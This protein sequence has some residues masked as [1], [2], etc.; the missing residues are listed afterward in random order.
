[1]HAG[2]RAPTRVPGAREASSS[3]SERADRDGLFERLARARRLAAI[4]GN[5]SPAV[6]VRDAALASHVV[7]RFVDRATFAKAEREAVRIGVATV[8]VLLANGWV[9]EGALVGALAWARGLPAVERDPG[10]R[11]VR[12]VMIR[13]APPTGDGGPRL[14]EPV[15]LVCERGRWI[16]LS[17][18]LDGPGNGHPARQFA[19]LPVRGAPGRMLATRR[20]FGEAVARAT[21]PWLASEAVSGLARRAPAASARFP[22]RTWQALVPTVLLG[23]LVGASTVWPL[24]V[25]SLVMLAS[26]VPFLAIV[27][28]RTAALLAALR[29][30]VADASEAA[31]P[32]RRLRDDELPVYSLLVPLYRETAVLPQLVRALSGLDYPLAKLDVLLVLEAAD[33]AM[34][35][36]VERLELPGAFRI[37]VVPDVPPRTKPKALAYALH[38][39]RGEH[40]VVYDAEDVPEPDQLRRVLAVFAAGP[41]SLACVQAALAAHNTGAGWLARQ[42]ALEYHALFDVLLPAL[43]AARAPIPLG[44]TSNHFRRRALEAVGG[45]DPFNVTEDADLG[46]R[47]ARAGYGVATTASTTWEEA[48]DH[49]GAWLKQRTR[50]LKG[51]LQTGLVHTREPARTVR[52]LGPLGA[53]TFLTLVGGIVLAALLHPWVYVLACVRAMRGEPWLGEGPLGTI[54]F[55]IFLSGYL[56]TMATGALAAV[57]RG[58]RSLLFAVLGMPLYWLLVSI[59]A[60]RALWQLARD[61]F[62]WEKT[63]HGRHPAP[64]RRPRRNA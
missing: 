33:P 13:A 44:G 43:A 36:A 60:Y 9:E 11:D 46:I 14:L 10:W 48:P 15:L 24:Q 49:F 7:G 20:A 35:A 6:P 23:L 4:T 41:A 30:P 61:P 29:S 55:G 21:L 1:M 18:A 63:E 19:S 38:F 27:A 58:R 57:R 3:Q 25:A 37:V 17:S 31:L 22:A 28:A 16:Q 8:E 56:V 34:R 5:G 26:T 42:F 52:E 64:S 12:L 53:A 47:L 45:W 51:W 39:A 54:A 62:R 2:P 50:W 59:A 40:V 32:A